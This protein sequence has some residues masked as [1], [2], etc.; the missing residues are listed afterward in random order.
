MLSGAVPGSFILNKDRDQVC[1]SVAI[2]QEETP[3]EGYTE[4]LKRAAVFFVGEY[5]FNVN[6]Y[7]NMDITCLDKQIQQYAFR[8]LPQAAEAGLRNS[9]RGRVLET[10]DY[11]MAHNRLMRRG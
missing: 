8:Q 10:A 7:Q 6:V 4:K 9:W 3:G 2:G 11:V 1:R 5:D